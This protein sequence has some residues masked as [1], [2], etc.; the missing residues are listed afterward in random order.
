MD[1]SRRSVGIIIN[2][3]KDRFDQ[4]DYKKYID[5]QEVLLK[6]IKGENW[7][8]HFQSI[9]NFYKGD[10]DSSSAR[11][12]ISLLPGIAST[13]GY[14][15]KSFTVADL[16]SFLQSLDYSQRALLTEVVT[17][18]KLILVMPATN[19][20]SERSFSAL[21]RVK[22]YLRSTTTDSR[23]NNLLVLHI[24]KDLTDNLD[25]TVIGNYF[26][27]KFDTRIGI[28]GYYGNNK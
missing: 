19:A 28:F 21:K 8:S 18:A 22:T 6:S 25:L 17:I 23:L 10:F 15:V 4:P 11:A 27:D 9:S 13:L 3:I 14:D 2:C 24:H 1:R 7:D 26:I 20:I 5:L 12:Q 16:I